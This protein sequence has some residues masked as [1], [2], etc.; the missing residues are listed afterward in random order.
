[1]TAKRSTAS[2]GEYFVRQ[3]AERRGARAV[4][5][6]RQMQEQESERERL[7]A[8]HYLRCPKCGMALET[9]ALQ[10]VQIDR[11]YSCNGTWLDEG[12]LEQLAAKE[13]GFVQ[14]L[15]GVFRI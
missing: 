1:M 3:E 2:E 15:V 11:C 10:G 6:Q 9:L 14:R 8:L 5:T 4:E 13:P 7:E 12:E